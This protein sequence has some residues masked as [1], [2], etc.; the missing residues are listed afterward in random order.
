M[1]S[2]LHKAK[3]LAVF[4]LMAFPV[5]ADLAR[6]PKGPI[7]EIFPYFVSAAL[8]LSYLVPLLIV[9][10]AIAVIAMKRRI[11]KR[12]IRYATH[13]KIAMVLA[14]VWLL[15]LAIC[16]TCRVELLSPVKSYRKLHGLCLECG[17]DTKEIYRY[18]LCP[19]CYIDEY[20]PTWK[21][22]DANERARAREQGARKEFLD[23]YE[24]FKAE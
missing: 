5:C 10:L 17:G 19:K 11:K 18:G 14:V 12:R 8:F 21:I 15:S 20:S 2:C 16:I 3:A 6:P 22:N 23:R 13:L 1:K 7:D 24:P 4:A 9:A